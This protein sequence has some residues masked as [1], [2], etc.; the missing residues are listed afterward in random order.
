MQFTGQIFFFWFLTI[1]KI[2][3]LNI[4]LQKVLAFKISFGLSF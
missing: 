1:S 2:V 4:Q 3:F